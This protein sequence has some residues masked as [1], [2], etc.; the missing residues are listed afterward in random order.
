MGGLGH[1]HLD[2]PKKSKTKERPI[3]SIVVNGDCTK[4]FRLHNDEKKAIGFAKGM[5]AVSWT[6]KV[7]V[8]SKGKVIWERDRDEEVSS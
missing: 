1:D 2:E 3:V 8:V 4:P 5:F 7:S 6:R